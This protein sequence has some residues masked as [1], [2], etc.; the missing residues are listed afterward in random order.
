MDDIIIMSSLPSLYM[1][2]SSISS[3]AEAKEGFCIM[4]D[5]SSLGNVAILGA[6]GLRDFKF[7]ERFDVTTVE[8]SF[9]RELLPAEDNPPIGVP[10][11]IPQILGLTF[12]VQRRCNKFSGGRRENPD[13]CCH[14]QIP[15]HHQNIG[16]P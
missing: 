9:C 8:S 16:S 6:T 15:P 14:C 7:L 10:L 1:S 12:D 3:S 13:H 4:Q 5:G 11:V 2:L